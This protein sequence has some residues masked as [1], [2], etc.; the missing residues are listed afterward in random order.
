[1]NKNS[2]KLNNNANVLDQGLYVIATPIGNRQDITLRA[3]ETMFGV[4]ILLCEDT[5]KTKLLLDYYRQNLITANV[6]SLLEISLERIPQL[7]S[8]FEHNEDQRVPEVLSYLQKGLKVGLVSN[9]GTPTISDPGYKLVKTCRESDI[10][11][12]SAPG[13]SA[14]ISAL[15]ISGLS[16]DKFTFLGFL[17]R[18]PGKQNKIWKDIRNSSLG[19]TVIFYESPFRVFKTLANMEK[20]FGNIEVTIARELTKKHEEVVTKPIIKWLEQKTF[21]GE[22]VVLFRCSKE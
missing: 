8:Y 4:D 2:T 19:Q 14:I 10:K 13:P 21:K 15:S 5:R 17:P 6:S 3:L 11:V 12:F 9:S 20:C 1:M 16:S 7:I 22:L 18:K